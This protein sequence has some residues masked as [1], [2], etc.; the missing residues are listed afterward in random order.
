MIYLHA[1]TWLHLS[2]PFWIG[3]TQLKDNVS[4]LDVS[5]Q[6]SIKDE[7]PNSTVT[8]KFAYLYTFSLTKNAFLD[9]SSKSNCLDNSVL[10]SLNFSLFRI[11]GVF[12]IKILSKE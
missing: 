1:N 6:S 7:M 12:E 10:K 5:S 9:I 11:L 3:R 4:N 8:P 2:A